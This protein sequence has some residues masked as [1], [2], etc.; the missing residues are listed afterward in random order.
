MHPIII[1]NAMK[2]GSASPWGDD[3]LAFAIKSQTL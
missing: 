3:T 2:K 1:A